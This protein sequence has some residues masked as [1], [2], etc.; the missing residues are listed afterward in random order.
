MLSSMTLLQEISNNYHYV[1]CFYLFIIK[2][3]QLEYM[4]VADSTGK[5]FTNFSKNESYYLQYS[6]GRC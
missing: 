6:E 1:G 2:W 3:Q 4:Q 5:Q